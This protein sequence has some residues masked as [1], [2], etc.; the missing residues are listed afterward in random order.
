MDFTVIR[1]LVE[2][3]GTHIGAPAH[4]VKGGETIDEIPVKKF[5]MPCSVINV[6]EKCEE[7]PDPIIY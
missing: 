5:V 1:S 7:N 6:E 2:H 4:F 3:Y